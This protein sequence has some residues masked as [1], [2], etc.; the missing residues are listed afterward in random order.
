MKLLL[1]V[2]SIF[3]ILIGISQLLLSYFGFHAY[4]EMFETLESFQPTLVSSLSDW[5]IVWMVRD[6]WILGI[7]SVLAGVVVFWKNNL[8]WSFFVAVCL[9]HTIQSIISLFK[10]HLGNEVELD[11]SLADFQPL[12]IAYWLIPMI[13]SLTGI[14]S[15]LKLK[16]H[17]LPMGEKKWYFLAIFSTLLISLIFIF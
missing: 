6:F 3:I 11:P 7:A 16:D 5:D 9:I 2:A 17:F 4:K 1:K 12:L 15:A 14:I 10:F 13:V 8:S